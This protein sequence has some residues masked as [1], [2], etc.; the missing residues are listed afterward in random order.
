M[1]NLKEWFAR[2]KRY[3]TPFSLIYFDLNGLKRVNDKYG[4]QAGDLFTL[5][6]GCY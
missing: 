2:S 6:C 1:Y 4:H 3:G 5:R